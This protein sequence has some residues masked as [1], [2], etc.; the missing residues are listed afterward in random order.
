MPDKLPR[1]QRH[2][3]RKPP[4]SDRPRMRLAPI[5]QEAALPDH[6]VAVDYG[7]AQVIK[8]QLQMLGN[9]RYG[10]CVAVTW[11]NDRLLTTAWLTP[12]KV[13]YP[14]LD[15]VLTLYKTQNPDFPDQDEGMVIQYALEYLVKT[16]GPDGV[17]AVAFAAV[18][19]GDLEELRTA[20]ALFGGI[21]LG[22][23]V[24]D[25]N[26]DQFSREQPWDYV[27]RSPV[28]GG[29]AVPGVGYDTTYIDFLTWAEETKL[30][31]AFR[32]HQLE[33]AW[34]V[35]WPEHLGS[36]TF[37]EGVSLDKLAEAYSA[38]TDGKV[39]PLPVTPEP[40]PTP[41]PTPEP[42]PEP[43]PEPTPEPTPDPFLDSLDPA[44]VAHVTKNA[45]RQHMTPAEY[46]SWK[47]AG[48]FDLR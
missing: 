5:L 44:V 24:T 6:P 22:V 4:I 31:E 20:I 23:N 14:S 34:V 35:V 30:T 17:K 15:D 25:A 39:L 33:E 32:Q 16:G 29:H 41:T 11:A 1:V 40:T 46:V 48:D 42:T 13:T 9:D 36:A 7:K 28:E 12:D 43:G 10:D 47:L 8:D 27:S 38:V 2:Y 26:Q 3:G 19:I 18:D 37:L 45:A 21:W